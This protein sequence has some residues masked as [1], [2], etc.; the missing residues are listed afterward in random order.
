MELAGAGRLEIR[1]RTL[2]D[3]EF[4]AFQDRLNAGSIALGLLAGP[5]APGAAIKATRVIL[6]QG[7]GQGAARVT[8]YY[9]LPDL[10]SLIGEAEGALEQ[11]LSHL[12]RELNFP[13]KSS[14]AGR[15]GN[16]E[17]F[18]LNAWL[19]A[20]QPFLIEAASPPRIAPGSPPRI[21][22]S[23]P[24]TLEICR[25]P[26]F[27]RARHLAHV[28]GRVHGDVVI[29]RLVFLEPGDQRVA[30]VSPEWLDQLGFQLFPAPLGAEHVHHDS[31]FSPGAGNASGYHRR[32]AKRAGGPKGSRQAG[33]HCPSTYVSAV[34]GWR[35]RAGFLA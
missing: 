23:G 8:A 31:P 30:V 9:S 14:Y 12:E 1:Q 3:Q 6:Q 26:D 35:S 5:G 16:F 18:H 10:A 13:F 4:K 24:E 25:T 34:G 32:R 28:T 29:D 19:D 27:A 22:R 11:L 15:I 7:L 2:V 17:V 20:P 33:V 21:D